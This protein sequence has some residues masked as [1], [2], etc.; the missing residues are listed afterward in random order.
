MEVEIPIP[1][2]MI[3]AAAP[4][5]VPPRRIKTIE[6]IICRFSGFECEPD[7]FL[8]VSPEQKK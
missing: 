8:L 4:N 2:K 7:Q 1:A 5:D 6:I 3:N